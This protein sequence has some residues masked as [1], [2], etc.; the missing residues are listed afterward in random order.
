MNWNI[1]TVLV[2][3]VIGQSLLL[4]VYFIAGY[5]KQFYAN[6]FLAALFLV[7]LI[8]LVLVLLKQTAIIAV[9][10]AWNC[11]S[12]FLVGPFLYFFCI[13]LLRS[14][15]KWKRLSWLHC[16]P[17]IIGFLWLNLSTILRIPENYFLAAPECF[18]FKL[19]AAFSWMIY[20]FFSLREIVLT[21]NAM[22]ESRSEI[23]ASVFNW[24]SLIVFN[25]SLIII[26]D[27]FS[28]LLNPLHI[29]HLLAGLLDNA[30]LFVFWLFANLLILKIMIS[31]LIFTALQQEEELLAESKIEKYRS[32]PLTKQDKEKMIGRLE[33]LMQ[34]EKPWS[35]PGITIA[36]LAESAGI[37]ARY[38]SQVINEN[39][40]ENF[41]DF[42][43]RYRIE[44]T[45]NRILNAS[46]DKE[47]ISEIM[48][49]VGFNSK[50][51]FNNAFKKITGQTPGQ[52]KKTMLKH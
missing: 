50:S 44:E 5:K 35:K 13:S 16:L 8:N 22:K 30:G 38:L 15:G 23:P 12:G 26:L 27:A 37:Q 48:Y 2:V 29:P 18:T 21:K 11:I 42:I 47:T 10:P 32:S 41:Y 6:R 31:P 40:N 33:Q 39:Y 45:K 52:F 34:K 1:F 4:A 51:S 24:C 25:F 3:L 7:V 14:S 49:Q 20:L 17:F 28:I 46:D 9:L 36:E 43:N 19:I